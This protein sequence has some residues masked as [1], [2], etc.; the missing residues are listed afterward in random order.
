[1]EEPMSGN[2]DENHFMDADDEMVE[3]LGAHVEG[4]FLRQEESFETTREGSQKLL[5]LLVA[6]IGGSALLLFNAMAS[7][8]AASGITMGLSVLLSGWF[9]CACVLLTGCIGIRERPTRFGYPSCLYA[10]DVET[11]HRVSLPRLR[12]FRLF[13]MEAS[14]NTLAAINR[15]RAR[16]LDWTRWG[17]A[18]VPVV[19]ALVITI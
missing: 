4:A 19:A 14:L 17:C 13:Y 11:G 12:R 6:G 5:N 3:Y 10:I 8:G 18:A 2:H 1:M 7:G 16:A 9:L 15:K